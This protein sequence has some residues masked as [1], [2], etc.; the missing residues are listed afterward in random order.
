M[1][2]EKFVDS[3][4]ILPDFY[5]RVLDSTNS[6]GTCV[7]SN[8]SRA[9]T[10]TVNTRASRLNCAEVCQQNKNKF[11][12][13]QI[14]CSFPESVF[15][16]SV[17]SQRNHCFIVTNSEQVVV[18]AYSVSE[19]FCANQCYQSGK[20]LPQGSDLNCRWQNQL[21]FSSNNL[22]VDIEKTGSCSLSATDTKFGAIA[23]LVFDKG[24][25]ESECSG[26]KNDFGDKYPG[27]VVMTF[28]EIVITDLLSGPT[29][30]PTLPA[31]YEGAVRIDQNLE[32]FYSGEWKGI[33]DDSFDQS[34]GEV[35][36]RQL[37]ETYISHSG[38]QSGNGQFWLDDLA[39]TGT[40]SNVTDCAKSPV[41]QHNCGPGEHVKLVC[42]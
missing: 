30:L 32:Y 14:A 23:T 41:G 25:S 18:D 6:F 13:E 5:D 38:G 1:S 26:F 20:I 3:L 39:C 17:N 42:Q 24:V 7:I 19:S 12:N 29:S 36:C 2:S 37:G 28:T 22:K 8:N 16:T 31:E 33:C 4:P 11:A 34:D 27:D 35:I 15:V 40:E 10:L 21:F 9:L